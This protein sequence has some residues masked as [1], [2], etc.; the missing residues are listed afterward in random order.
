MVGF[1][2]SE[3]TPAGPLNLEVYLTDEHILLACLIILNATFVLGVWCCRSNFN[4]EDWC[5]DE[6]LY[7]LAMVF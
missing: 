7:T 6:V 4:V 2:L 3:M 5:R 1:V